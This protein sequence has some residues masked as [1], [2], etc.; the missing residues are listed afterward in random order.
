MEERVRHPLVAVD[1]LQRRPGKESAEDR[2]ESEPRRKH[3]EQRKQEHRWQGQQI[4]DVAF[5]PRCARGTGG[6]TLC[7]VGDASMLEP[8]FHVGQVR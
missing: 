8:P 7:Q 5:P 3:D 2:L 6:G 1:E 4:L